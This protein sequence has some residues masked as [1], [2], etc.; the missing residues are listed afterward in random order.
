VAA[1][2]ANRGE[3]EA[4]VVP[5]ASSID[6][7][8]FTY[9]CSV[10]GLELQPGGYVSIAER[11]GQVHSVELGEEVAGSANV[12]ITLVRGHGVLLEDGVPPF[13]ATAF[14]RAGE[15]AVAAWLERVQ[16]ERASLDVGE[17]VLQPG[18]RF[19]LD[20]GGFDRHTFFC[21]QSGSGKTY[22]L[23]TVLERLLL[24]TTLRIVVLD[25][26]S[27]FVRLH[28]TRDGVDDAM[29]SRYRQATA[30][31]VV[32]RGAPV[33]PER[34]HVRFTDCDAEEQAAVLRLDPI[35][36]REEYGALLDLLEGGFEDSGA[37]TRELTERLLGPRTRR[38]GR[39]G[40]VFAISGFAAGRSGR[41]G[42]LSPCR[43]W[44]RPA[45][46]AHSWSISV[47][48]R[49]SG[50]RRSRPRACSPRSGGIVLSESRS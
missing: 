19:A 36:D 47:R 50:R 8:R 29:S 42:T 9:Q 17:L 1:P 44:S 34:L 10:H 22:A 27:D 40:L 45:G 5:T 31:I 26:N 43:T 6:G 7:R 41:S 13:H 39:W 18:V 4:S 37:S 35:R 48:R 11:L 20:A 14:E 16:P 21:G 23:G 24:E 15:A 12:R 33:G 32:R 30:G 25:P 38:F 28:D 46:P 3:L 49:R 2:G